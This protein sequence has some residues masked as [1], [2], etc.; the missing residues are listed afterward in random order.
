MDNVSYYS[1]FRINLS[2]S[3]PL[4]FEKP[5][6]T[7]FVR[8]WPLG[9]I[10]DTATNHTV[11]LASLEEATQR[12]GA[13]QAALRATHLKYHLSTV[14]VLTAEQVAYTTNCLATL[15]FETRGA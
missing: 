1:N 3:V 12:I 2:L 7:M 13:T 11:T 4:L 9:A 15:A 10:A 8:F 14:A 5:N 6:L